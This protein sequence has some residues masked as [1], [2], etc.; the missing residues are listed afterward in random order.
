MNEPAPA[1]TVNAPRPRMRPFRKTYPTSRLSSDAQARE[2]RIVTQAFLALGRDAAC[3][4]LNSSDIELGG[5]PL[6]IATASDEGEEI[7]KC[8]IEAKQRR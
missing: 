4:F 1:L 7:I 6:D 8:A 5:R 2:G 3:E